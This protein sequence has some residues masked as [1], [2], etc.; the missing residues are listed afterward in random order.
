VAYG[1][2]FGSNLF[3]TAL[4]TGVDMVAAQAANIIGAE[5]AVGSFEKYAAH[6]ALG[7]GVGM[8]KSGSGDGC[9]PAAT[10]AVAGHMA[11]DGIKVALADKTNTKPIALMA[12]AVPGRTL[13]DGG[14]FFGGLVGGTAAALATGGKNVQ[15]DFALGQGAAEN[16]I[17]NNYLKFDERKKLEQAEKDCFAGGSDQACATVTVLRQKDQLTDRLLANAAASCKGAECAE[18][19]TFIRKEMSDLGCPTLAACPD[20]KALAAY[21]SAAQ[22]KAQGL[23]MVVPEA[24]LL[25][26]KAA[27][28]LGKWGIKA[29]SNVAGKSSLEALQT[30]SR[31]TA[32]D[33]A[34]ARVTN[35]FYRDGVGENGRTRAGANAGFDTTNLQSKLEG[36]LLDPAHPQ[37]QTKATWFQQAL[38]FDKKNWQQLGS[39]ITFN[40]S[41]AI[42]TKTT[43][44]GQT[45]EQVIPIKGANGK[46]IDV[47]FVFMKDNT[48]TVRLVTGIPAKK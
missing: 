6:A 11:A 22:G 38:G 42:A 10:G 36:Y 33:A 14:V 4:N 29:V 39:Q 23:E 37:N 21:W 18:V 7:C 15:G 30:I 48:G 20:Q 2:D 31:T 25:D 45:F 12:A 16:A 9:V 8:V 32:D 27:A 28:D 24:W 47:P 13:D 35:N 3:D 34:L 5:T 44:Y 19:A 26:V 46:I 17:K 43:Q 1:G 41:T 40:E